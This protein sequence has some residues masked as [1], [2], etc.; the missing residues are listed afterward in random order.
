MDL[1]GIKVRGAWSTLKNV[2]RKWGLCGV[3]SFAAKYECTYSFMLFATTIFKTIAVKEM[4]PNL[5]R[6]SSWAGKML[7]SAGNQCYELA[8]RRPFRFVCKGSWTCHRNQRRARRPDEYVSAKLVSDDESLPYPYRLKWNW[9]WSISSDL[10]FFLEVNTFL[11]FDVCCVSFRC[12]RRLSSGSV[13]LFRGF[14]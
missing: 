8:S 13:R 3:K 7:T 5:V 1:Y 4:E 2:A 14:R 9:T 11:F 6:M 12:F 10:I